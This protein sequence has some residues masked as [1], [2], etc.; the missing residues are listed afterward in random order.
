MKK[1]SITGL[2]FTTL[3]LASSLIFGLMSRQAAKAK[4]EFNSSGASVSSAASFVTQDSGVVLPRTGIYALN[5]DNTIFVLPPG[6]TSFTRLVRVT[7]ANGNLIGIDFRVADGLLYALT[8]TGSLYTISLSSNNLGAVT[9]VSNLSPRFAGGFRSLMDFNPV[10]NALRLIGT[11]DQNFA[12]V[13][14][15]G[16]LNAT[17]VQTAVAYAAGDVNA[18]KDPNIAGGSYT[19][20]F[21]GATVTLF[22]AVDYDLDTLVT[23]QPA[24]P[25]GSSATGGGQLQT[26]GRLVT[27]AGSPINISPTADFDIYTDANRVNSIVGVSGRTLFTIDLSQINPSLPLGTTQNV[28]AR[29]ITMPDTGGGF[30][31]TAVA[32][33][34]PT[35]TPTPTL[36]SKPTPTPTPAGGARC[37][38][39][40]VVT[41]QWDVGFN[42]T[43]NIQ[44]N[45]GVALNGWSLTWSFSG[46]QKITSFYNTAITQSGQG[47]KA[48]NVNFNAKFPNGGSYLI[49]FQASYSGANPIPNNFALNGV[50]C[51]RQ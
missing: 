21:A 8:D 1:M 9:F 37:S 15:G 14:S 40:Y 45:T 48:S 18:G 12:A 41:G 34:A 5:A 28:V 33:A 39:N 46:N 47:V 10:V 7:Q 2:T 6:A 44:N 31:D 36:T 38:V 29:G 22:Y 23:I 24:T 17:A 19:N 13:N 42:T 27:D 49:G 32:P 3:V 50:P 25:G 11:N 4:S 16:N 43:I 35:P 30:I 20:N 51:V 26:I